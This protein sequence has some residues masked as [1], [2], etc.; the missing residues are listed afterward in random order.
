MQIYNNV[1]LS[2]ILWYQI[3]GVA[4]TVLD[5]ASKEDLYEALS[6][7]KENNV[8]KVFILGLGS[9]LLFSDDGYDGVIIRFLMQEDGQGVKLLENNIVEA[10]AGEFLDSVIQAQFENG[11]VGLEWAGGLPGTVGAAVRGNVGAF[12]G[13]IKDVFVKAHCIRLEENGD[14]EELTLSS[15]E[16]EFSYRSSKVKTARSASS[17]L[18]VVSAQFQLR[19]GNP[20]ELLSAHEKYFENITYRQDKHPLDYPNCGSVFKNISRPEGVARILESWNDIKEMVNDKWHGKVSMG[21]IIDRLGLKGREIGGAQ[22][23]EKHQNFI[24]NKGGAKASDVKNL[25]VEVE[26]EMQK[27][28]GIMPEVEIEIVS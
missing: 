26:K 3:G 24:V 5:V 2:T 23:S 18:V 1:L 13:E 9:N 7:V 14:F 28:F 17:V 11:L 19:E 15:E 25:I 22:I 6:Y 21:Y 4:K 12:G 16:M 10:F 20:E 27:S 8:S